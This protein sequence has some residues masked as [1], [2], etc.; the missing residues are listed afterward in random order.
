MYKS[1]FI[2]I[3][4]TFV[5]NGFAQTQNFWTKK[6][7]F[8]GLKRERAV[9][10]SINN[11][12]YI[13]TGIDTA[14]VLKKDLWEYDPTFDTWTQK[15]DLPSHPRRNAIAFTVN[16]LAYVGTGMDSAQASNGNTLSDFW[17]YNPA[18]NNWLQKADFPGSSG[19]GLYF[20]TGFSANSK[21]FVCGG[22]RGP[23]DYTAEI[24]AYDPSNDTWTQ[25]TDFPGGVRYQLCSFSVDDL[26]YVG[27]GIDQDVYRKDIWQYNPVT[28]EWTE[29][30]DFLGG[31]RGAVTTFTMGQRGFVCLGNDGGLKGD[32]WEYN[33]FE[34]SWTVRANY[35]GSNRKN[36][37]AFV[38][39]DSVFVGTGKGVSGKKSSMHMYTPVDVLSIK[40]NQLS[41]KI[42]PNPT[43]DFL[44]VTNNNQVINSLRIY[45]LNGQIVLDQ[46]I[47]NE[48]VKL[49]LDSLKSGTY[50]LVG[51]NK[52]NSVVTSQ[53]FI[54]Q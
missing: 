48:S 12:G 52:N 16:N 31:E 47:S 20:A 29:K 37:V 40:S 53:Q 27:L 18:S 43:S 28:D 36:A 44:M 51:T 24:W 17:S 1:I 4:I 25:G 45:N 41:L 34:D 15:S 49:E 13:A 11:K 39:G 32:L 23:N 35:G 5:Q 54:I 21:G 9:A 22:K 10:F 30:N 3:A 42:Y 38:I 14:D 26:G 33:P 46:K 2:L 19:T 8:S 50:I 7:D 6:S